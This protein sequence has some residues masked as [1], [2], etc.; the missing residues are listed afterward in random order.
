LQ[1][2]ESGQ[3]GSMVGTGMFLEKLR[4]EINVSHQTL[5]AMLLKGVVDAGF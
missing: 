5:R 3:T 4:K 2:E 1:L